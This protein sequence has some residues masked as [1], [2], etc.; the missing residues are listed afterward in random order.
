M[1]ID[2]RKS[3]P[4]NCID[5]YLFISDLINEPFMNLYN[6]LQAPG[7]FKIC[8]SVNPC[9]FTEITCIEGYF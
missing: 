2:I 3:S 4:L 5:F 7:T 1:E 6:I 9:L 8:R